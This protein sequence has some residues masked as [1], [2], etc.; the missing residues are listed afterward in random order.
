MTKYTVTWKCED[1][2]ATGE[3]VIEAESS[4]ASE[5]LATKQA[6]DEISFHAKENGC[7][8]RLARIT[9]SKE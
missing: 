4:R 1:C 9:E 7:H 5:K 6:T 2:G 8:R 3:V